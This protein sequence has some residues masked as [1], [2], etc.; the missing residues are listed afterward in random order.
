MA[1]SWAPAA[2]PAGSHPQSGTSPRPSAWETWAHAPCCQASE[3]HSSG[4]MDV[5]MDVFT[6]ISDGIYGCTKKK[7][8]LSLLLHCWHNYIITVIL[9]AFFRAIFSV[10]CL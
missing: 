9:C 4:G 5:C 10:F 7:A 1:P 2:L 6:V 3:T 8:G